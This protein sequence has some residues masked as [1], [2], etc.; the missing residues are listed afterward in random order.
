MACGTLEPLRFENSFGAGCEDCQSLLS[1]WRKSTIF[2]RLPASVTWKSALVKSLTGC[3]WASTAITFRS[4][5]RGSA[6]R[7]VISME[8]HEGQRQHDSRCGMS[9]DFLCITGG[10]HGLRLDDRAHN[11]LRPLRAY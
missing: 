9:R 4:I 1:L 7:F 3:W 11:I 8:R 5:R 10:G 2:W 6:C